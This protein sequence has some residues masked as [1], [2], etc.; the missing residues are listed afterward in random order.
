MQPARKDRTG[1][2]TKST[3]DNTRAIAASRDYFQSYPG[4]L[5][6]RNVIHLDPFTALRLQRGAEHLDRLGPRATA[7]FLAEVANRIGGMPCI[8]ETL[9]DYQRRLTPRMLHAAGG[10][11]FPGSRPVAVPQ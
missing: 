6:G 5:K 11:R 4:V 3:D 8:L 7:E 9:S 10:N 2:E 1:C